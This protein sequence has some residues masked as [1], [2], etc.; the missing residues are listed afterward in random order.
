M[1]IDDDDRRH[2]T[3]NITTI[4]RIFMLL[5]ACCHIE[6]KFD[7]DSAIAIVR[8]AQYSNLSFYNDENDDVV[9]VH[10]HARDDII[11]NNCDVIRII[12]CHYLEIWRENNSD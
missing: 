12:V 10:V 8:D 9:A 3:L 7:F 1:S 11:N 4:T 2:A 5:A 6:W